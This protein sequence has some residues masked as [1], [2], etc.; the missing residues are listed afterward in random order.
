MDVA[1][2]FSWRATKRR[3]RDLQA[4]LCHQGASVTLVGHTLLLLGGQ[5]LL[6]KA[7]S[8]DTKARKW[9][10]LQITDLGMI[11][12][13]GHT[14]SLVGA[15]LW[16]FGV[17]DIRFLTAASLMV[18]QQSPGVYILDT[19]LKEVAQIRTYGP[20]P[21]YRNGHTMDFDE[22]RGRLIMVGAHA[23]ATDSVL[24]FLDVNT[25]RWNE[26]ST[27]GGKPGGVRAHASALVGSRLFIFGAIRQKASR[28]FILDLNHLVWAE[29]DS[30][31]PDRIG[32]AV[33]YVG[34]GRT[35]VYGGEDADGNTTNDL[36][37]VKDIS[38]KSH[39]VVRVHGSSTASASAE[40]SYSG[41][42]PPG[43]QHGHL[44]HVQNRLFLLGGDSVDES[45]YYELLPG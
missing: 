20:E 37:I 43:K 38:S 44:I 33:C 7:F 45:S 32:P 27:K 11:T 6:N 4:G 28:I 2:R 8:L 30:G 15:D 14:A 42:L 36:F 9:T 23:Q 34:G 18:R 16:L 35:F 26:P 1:T 41:K 19:L 24:W 5:S 22:E 40:F 31:M 39:T 17:E 13:R 12:A 10:E 21:G 3:G 29:M 25:R